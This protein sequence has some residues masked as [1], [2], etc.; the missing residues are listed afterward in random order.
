MKASPELYA[1]N[2]YEILKKTD[3]S[4]WDQISQVV[5]EMLYKKGQSK[6][7]PQILRHLEKQEN[8][9]NQIMPVTVRTAKKMDEQTIASYLQQVLP[10]VKPRVTST[11]NSSLIG[12]LVIETQDQ[13][14]DLSVHGQLNN[15]ANTIINK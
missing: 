1:K 13:R 12:G 6:W 11:I 9:E 4:A 2:W 8:Q 15:L 14:W 10:Q 7:L 3:Q 5:L